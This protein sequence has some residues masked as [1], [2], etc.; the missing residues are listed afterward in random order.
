MIEAIE[1]CKSFDKICA[2]DRASIQIKEGNVFGLV[3]TNGA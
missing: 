2:V 1:A 3:G